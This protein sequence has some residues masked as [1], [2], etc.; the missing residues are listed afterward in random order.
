[1]ATPGST[2]GGLSAADIL[3]V[4]VDRATLVGRIWDPAVGGPTPILIRRG[5]ETIESLG[6]AQ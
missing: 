3:P 4:D 1:M 2:L 5:R 6:S